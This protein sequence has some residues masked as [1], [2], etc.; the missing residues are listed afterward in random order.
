MKNIKY[1]SFKI[2]YKACKIKKICLILL[3]IFSIFILNSSNFALNKN[4]FSLSINNINVYAEKEDGTSK[5]NSSPSIYG[6]IRENSYD[7]YIQN[8]KS[9][10]SPNIEIS[11]PIEKYTSTN[12]KAQ[13]YY[14]YEGSKGPSVRT[15]EDGYIEWEVYVEK[16]GLYNIEIEYFPVEGRSSSIE[17]ELHINGEIPFAEASSFVF[18]RVWKDAEE[19]RS[20]NRGNELRPKQVEE[21]QWQRVYLSD[22]M[23]YYNEPFKFYFKK[24]INTIRLVSVRE[25]MLI[26]SIKLLNIKEIPDYNTVKQ[27]LK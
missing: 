26:K 7:K 20:D 10:E 8:Y 3:I 23:G 17:R 22:Y 25:P 13:I 4:I 2:A 5:N 15:E 18:S 11:I 12:M 1:S 27:V 19:I 6:L 21:P 16:E 24:G 9:S 14:D